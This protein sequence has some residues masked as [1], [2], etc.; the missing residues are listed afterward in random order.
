MNF[1]KIL[2][3]LFFSFFTFAN[4]YADDNGG[5]DLFFDAVRV[6]QETNKASASLLQRHLKVGY[7]RAARLLDI[8]EEKNLIGPSNGAKAREVY[9]DKIAQ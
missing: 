2:I 3:I 8:M 1:F 7:A 9:I 5:D 6:I 4:I